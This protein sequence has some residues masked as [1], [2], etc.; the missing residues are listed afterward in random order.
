[1]DGTMCHLPEL[2][3]LCDKHK[4]LL[5][6]DEAHG[7]GTLGL[8]GKGVQDYF[9]MPHGA[10]IIVGTFSKSLSNLGGYICGTKDFI[11][12]C[13]YYSDANVFTAGLSSYHAAGASS[14]LSEINE[15]I[16][17]KLLNNT[18]YLR[19]KLISKGFDVRGH[20][21]SP[22]IPV[23]FMYDVL[24]LIDICDHMQSKGFIVCPIL[25]PACSIF[26]PRLRVTATVSH[27]HTDID[28]FVNTLV[29][30]TQIYQSKLNNDSLAIIRAYKKLRK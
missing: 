3:K 26:E 2:R 23:I 17:A 10:D 19:Q 22:I 8:H 20:D 1:M 14:A 6:I 15:T 16:V 7:L 30:Y 12:N 24:K 4:A 18:R 28:L 25:P 21:S 29:T 27:T 13:E 11:K 9:N 5:V